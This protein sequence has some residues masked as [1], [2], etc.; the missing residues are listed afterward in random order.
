MEKMIHEQSKKMFKIILFEQ[1]S[2][3]E[4]LKDTEGY[5]PK[6]LKITQSGPYHHH[7]L[8][9][10]LNAPISDMWDDHHRKKQQHEQQRLEEGNSASSVDCRHQS[11]NVCHSRSRN[12]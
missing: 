8:V 11:M 4:T 5:L 3:L 12:V 1:I 2:R 9:L 6:T 7:Y 10:H